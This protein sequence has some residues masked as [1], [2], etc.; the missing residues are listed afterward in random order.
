M[1][2]FLS[3]FK[4]SVISSKT[5]LAIILTFI[6]MLIGGSEYIF[7]NIFDVG[8]IYIYK[9]AYSDGTISLI[10]FLA[11]IIA[12][13]PF[14][15]S[16]IT[17]R[18]SNFTQYIYTKLQPGK[19]IAIKIFLNAFLG[20]FVLLCGAGLFLIFIILLKGFNINDLITL[21]N[22]ISNIF[23]ISPLI[24]ILI[25]L[26]QLFIFGV[27]L[28]TLCLV[29]SEFVRN[30]YLS[31][32]CTFFIYMIIGVTSSGYCHYLN[33]QMLYDLSIYPEIGILYRLL[34]ATLL[35]VVSIGIFFVRVNSKEKIIE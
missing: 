9:Y 29:I 26:L 16:Y 4:R 34:Y 11:P 32:V 24:Y 14:A 10:V 2:Y 22:S 17:E 19:Y 23:E 12:C 25:E 21:N 27:V 28:S 1:K 8:A 30:K 5:L 6:C 13:I 7:T 33:I 3:E 15:T 18:E 31:V 20:G 35:L